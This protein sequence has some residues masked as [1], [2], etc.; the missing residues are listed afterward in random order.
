MK[1]FK[2]NYSN[3]ENVIKII[4]YHHVIFNCKKF[5]VFHFYCIKIFEIAWFNS[6]KILSLKINPLFLYAFVTKY[7][8]YVKIEI[9]FRIILIIK[10]NY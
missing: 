2:R 6:S 7:T 9:F 4:F 5:V 8:N 10:S 3:I 1:S